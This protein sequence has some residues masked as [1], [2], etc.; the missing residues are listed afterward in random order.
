LSTRKSIARILNEIHFQFSAPIFHNMVKFSWKLSGFIN[1]DIMPFVTPVQL[2]FQLCNPHK[3]CF[4][5]NSAPFLECSWCE[6][7]LCFD[8]FIQIP[9]RCNQ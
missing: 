7:N 8:H 2:C 9:H 5:C 6:E 3:N 1:D 4:I